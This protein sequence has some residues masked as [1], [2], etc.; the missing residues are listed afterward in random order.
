[1][2]S[3]RSSVLPARSI[4]TMVLSK[5]G[6]SGFDG[7]RLD[8]LAVFGHALFERRREVLVV[9][10]VEARV[11]QGSV[12]GD[13]Q[14]VGRRRVG[15]LDGAHERGHGGSHEQ[16]AQGLERGC[17][18]GLVQGAG[19]ADVDD[20]C[21]RACGA[22]HPAVYRAAGAPRRVPA[23][24]AT[25]GRT[26]VREP[27]SRPRAGRSAT[28]LLVRRVFLRAK[29]VGNPA[30]RVDICVT[31]AAIFVSTQT[32]T[33]HTHHVP[34]PRA[35]MTV[36][37]PGRTASACGSAASAPAPAFSPAR[38]ASAASLAAA[39]A[40]SLAAA[41]AVA[42]QP[43]PRPNRRRRLRRRPR[44]RPRRRRRASSRRPRWARAAREIASV[45]SLGLRRLARRA[46]RAARRRHALG[47]ARRAGLHRGHA[48][49][50]PGRLRRHGL[51]QDAQ[52]ARHAAP[53]HH[54]RAVRDLRDRASTASSAAAGSSSTP[55]R[56]ADLLEANAFGSHRAWLQQMSLSG[57][58]GDFLTFRGSA[59]AGSRQRR[60]A[61]R[62]LRPRADAA[63]HDR[64]GDA[65]TPTA[66][67]S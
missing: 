18:S 16:V 57:A 20:G 66:R 34:K 26:R 35:A 39:L 59:K 31:A 28:L 54:V 10:L 32:P 46:V 1:M 15:G 5:V 3:T 41:A 17:M 2:V 7:D 63:V 19:G 30:I 9:D 25:N 8:L 23:R 45:V 12:L 49:E 62:E 51:A 50:R 47:L 67:R 14:R 21:A 40:A 43:R 56:W 55:R 4:A 22:A 53:A 58:M 38:A 52:R 60:A 64:P 6:L 27:V 24:R 29:L 11:V 44:R 36:D 65:R 61:R 13:E 48:Q 42:R 37:I 33:A